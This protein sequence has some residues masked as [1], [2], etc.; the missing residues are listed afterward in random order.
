VSI[1]V[2]TRILALDHFPISGGGRLAGE[3]A[4]SA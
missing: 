2:C 4:E 3:Q 1:A